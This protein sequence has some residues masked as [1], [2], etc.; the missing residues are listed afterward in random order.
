MFFLLIGFWVILASRITMESLAIGTVASIAVLYYNR[1]L[2]FTKEEGGPVTLGYLWN[3]LVLVGVLL[4][5]IVKSNIAVAKIVL[6][7]KLPIQ[8]AFVWVPVRL[9]KDFHKVLY[10]NVVT[11]TPGTLTVDIVGD[12]YIIHVLTTEAAEGMEG[13]VLEAHVM[14]LEVEK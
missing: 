4:V 6:D 7:P 8:P 1:D 10:G 2:L 9:K 14:R 13:S 12:E 3:F 5:E 11:L